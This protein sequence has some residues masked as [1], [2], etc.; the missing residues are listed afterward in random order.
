MGE[1]SKKLLKRRRD[2]E[3]WER[4]NRVSTALR[5]WRRD[6][7]IQLA[8]AEDETEINLLHWEMT[9]CSKLFYR[10]QQA[11]DHIANDHIKKA[12]DARC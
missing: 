1:V 3:A 6:L 2:N 10:M 9:Q 4:M 5:L 7:I 8:A 12:S 11:W